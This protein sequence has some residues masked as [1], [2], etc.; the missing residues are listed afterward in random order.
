MG[1]WDLGL[2]GVY[3]EKILKGSEI[4]LWMRNIQLGLYGIIIGLVGI[5]FT[6]DGVMVAEKG[7]F[8]GYTTLTLLNIAVQ[9]GGG[10]MIAVVIKYADNILKNF[11]TAISII[12]SM[13]FSWFFMDFHLTGL[14]LLGV[15]MVNYA[16]YMYGKKDTSASQGSTLPTKR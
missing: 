6:N 14:F 13:A 3:F 1:L 9:G 8:Q 15:F 12:L 2:A 5:A 7:F 4:S 16:V 11:A 10:L